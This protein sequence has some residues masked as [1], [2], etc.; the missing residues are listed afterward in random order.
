[1]QDS[2][3]TLTKKENNEMMKVILDRIKKTKLVK[4]NEMSLNERVYR[5][6]KSQASL[7]DACMRNRLTVIETANKLIEFNLCQDVKSAFSRIKRHVNS[8]KKSR[9]EKRNIELTNSN[10]TLKTNVEIET[11]LEVK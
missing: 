5:T 9:V 11:S 3:L 10:A 1:M 2:T 8:D 4:K 7:I 6:C